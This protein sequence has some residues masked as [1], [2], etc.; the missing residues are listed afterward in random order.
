M[1][2]SKIKGVSCIKRKGVE[3]WYARINGLKKYCG[4]T[5]TLFENQSVECWVRLLLSL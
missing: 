4:R 1:A 5:K 2:T 3:Y